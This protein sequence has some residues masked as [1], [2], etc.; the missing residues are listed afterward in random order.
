M[1]VTLLTLKLLTGQQLQQYISL[2]NFAIKLITIA[3]LSAVGVQYVG[4]ISL[5][6]CGLGDGKDSVHME[7][8]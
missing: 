4:I 5:P 8:S 1:P 7:E 3:C 2:G 6:H